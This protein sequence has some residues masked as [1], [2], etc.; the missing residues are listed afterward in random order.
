MNQE[1]NHQAKRR[2]LIMVYTG[3]GKGKTTA[4]L[5]LALRAI[6]HGFKVYMVQFMKGEGN[7]YGEYLAASK[8]L[9]GF[10]IVRAGRDVFVDR[11]NPSEEDR[12]LAKKGLELA[13]RAITCGRYELVILD[14]VN[15]AV[16]WGL[17]RVEDVLDLLKDKPPEVD[18]VLTGRY[19]KPEIMEAADM[20]SEVLEVKHHYRAGIPAREGIEF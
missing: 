8:Y 9:P 19:A 4:A 13:R 1:M 14:E 12:V 11:G 7:L 6:G 10:E 18:V 5:G 16:E 3:N 20:V 17:L 15:V 2:G